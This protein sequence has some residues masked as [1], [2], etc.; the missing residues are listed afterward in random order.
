MTT[1]CNGRSRLRMRGCGEAASDKVECGGN[2]N[3]FAQHSLVDDD[4]CLRRWLRDGAMLFEW[5]RAVC[6]MTAMLLVDP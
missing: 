5:G 4:Q 2:T 1:R 6:L 3:I